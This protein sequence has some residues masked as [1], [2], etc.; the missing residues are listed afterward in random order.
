M[1]LNGIGEV[2]QR[3]VHGAHVAQLASLGELAPGLSRQ[4]HTLL[5]ARQRVRVVT[6]GGVHVAQTAESV[7][8]SL[9]SHRQV[10]VGIQSQQRQAPSTESSKQQ[11]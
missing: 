6:D 11:E 10:P 3:R 1:A 5:M 8:R 9:K 2:S 4:K 7:G